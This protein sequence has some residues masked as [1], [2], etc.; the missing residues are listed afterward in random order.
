M[1]FD[2]FSPFA[3]PAPAQP[4]PPADAPLPVAPA[5]PARAFQPLPPARPPSPTAARAK[6]GLGIVA[7]FAGAGVGAVLGGPLGAVAGLT[8][9][10]TIRNLYRS[11][12][13][14]SSDPAEQGDAARSLALGVLGVAIVGYVGYKIYSSSKDDD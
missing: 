6:A 9:I 5:A 2:D 4:A 12:G 7:A 11:Q 13:I 14:A 1:D 8:G 3:A 10:G